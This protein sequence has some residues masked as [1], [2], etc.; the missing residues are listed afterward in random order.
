MIPDG[1]DFVA[2]WLSDATGSDVNR[3]SLLEALLGV[4]EQSF[5]DLLF[6]PGA[7][8]ARWTEAAAFVGKAMSVKAP[9]GSVM[10][11]GEVLGLGSDGAL[12]LRTSGGDVR[13]LLGDVSAI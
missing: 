12:L 4:Y 7:V 13:A 3:T 1:L 5:D 2:A 10:H 6:A 9:D 8:I 11:E